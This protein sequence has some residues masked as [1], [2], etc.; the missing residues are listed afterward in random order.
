MQK[1]KKN[2][3]ISIQKNDKTKKK[4]TR[5]ETE[6]KNNKTNRKQNRQS[7]LVHLCKF[8]QLDLGQRNKG[9]LIQKAQTFS[10]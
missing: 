4:T 5:G 7:T 9:T 2:Q 3:N 1:R 8:R 6:K 10:L